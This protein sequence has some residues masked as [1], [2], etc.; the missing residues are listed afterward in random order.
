MKL[1]I[2]IGVQNA[3]GE[4][5]KLIDIDHEITGTSLMDIAKTLMQSARSAF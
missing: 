4:E 1:F 5:E 3:A 2:H